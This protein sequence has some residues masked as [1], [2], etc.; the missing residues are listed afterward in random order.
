MSR[1][2]FITLAMV[3]GLSA[4]NIARPLPAAV[5]QPRAKAASGA[6]GTLSV[7]TYNVKGLPFPAALGRPAALEKIAEQLGSLRLSGRQPDVVAL[8]EAFVPEAKAIA[9][10]AGYKW[11]AIGPQPSEALGTPSDRSE[12]LASANLANGASWTRG[13]TE[14][15]WVDSGL[16]IM[17]DYPIIAARRMAFPASLCAGFDC[18]ASKGLLVAWVRVP[19]Q[20]QPVAV[21]NTHL[22]SRRAS[23]VSVDRANQAYKLQLAAAF[24]FIH[25]QVPASQALV[26]AGDFNVGHDPDRISGAKSLIGDALGTAEASSRL[27]GAETT[28]RPELAAIV[29]RGKDKQYYRSG[30]ATKLA[31]GAM[32]VP[33]GAHPGADALSDHIGYVVTYC[34]HSNDCKQR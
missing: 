31:F 10:R 21:A 2:G 22:N 32:D 18:L 20:A 12:R 15:K 25:A 7:M 26:F 14:G 24:S 23:G 34:F 8:Q 28:L 4:S 17:S 33:F 16:V 3:A 6:P 27:P 13:E 11:I 30:T 5:Y 19:G 9:A 1:L 29:K